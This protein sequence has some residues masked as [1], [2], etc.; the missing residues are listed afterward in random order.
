MTVPNSTN[1]DLAI[2]DEAV[3]YIWAGWFIFVLSSSL[4]G[5]TIILIASIKYKAIKLHKMMVVI[6]QHIA[7]SNLAICITESFPHSVSLITNR[8]IFGTT[9][10]YVKPF[11][12][13]FVYQAGIFLVCGMVTCKLLIL[14]YPGRSL[15]WS[16][17][18]AHKICF[19]IW[20]LSLYWPISY[21]LV[22]KDDMSFDY[23]PYTC[24]YEFSS[25][26]WKFLQ[27]ANF[28]IFNVVPN[29]VI[30]VTAVMILAVTK[31]VTKESRHGM[32]WQG[33]I[34]VVLTA[35]AFIISYLPMAVYHI[36]KSFVEKDAPGPFRI[37]YYR[38]A[39]SLLNINVIANFYI[40]CLTVSSFRDFLRVR[41]QRIT[42]CSF[43]IHLRNGGI[44]L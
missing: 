5:D 3:R 19:L 28:V 1:E 31:R 27:P 41:A 25:P 21:L 39:N 32:N 43:K 12:C 35:A 24:T 30:V 33:V 17:G 34:T 23:R 4:V 9:I 18:R 40:Y 38:V 29:C 36:L 22:D 16:A 42:S 26:T 6:I 37:T 2:K 11:V 13:A 20:L 8:W 14:K 7:V 10:C 44:F 15:A